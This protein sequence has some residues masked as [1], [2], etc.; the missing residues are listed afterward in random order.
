VK[1]VGAAATH[2]F[3]AGQSLKQYNLLNITDRTVPLHERAMHVS[4]DS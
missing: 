1:V 2:T 3:T 4:D